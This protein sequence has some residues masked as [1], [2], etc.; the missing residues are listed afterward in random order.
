MA[1]SSVKHNRTFVFYGSGTS[2][3]LCNDRMT[4]YFCMLVLFVT[5]RLCQQLV[6][7]HSAKG[8]KNENIHM[9]SAE[10]T[11]LELWKVYDWFECFQS[12]CGMTFFF[13][14][15][16]GVCIALNTSAS[17]VNFIIII[18]LWWSWATCWSVPVSR[19]QKSLQRF[20]MIP[21]ASW[22]IVFHYPG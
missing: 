3:S 14:G 17:F 5:R 16:R 8:K 22:R 2:G 15:G 6:A 13:G 11:L 18:Y 1:N 12:I 20:A 10:N 9:I 21:S 7:A 19:I 4:R